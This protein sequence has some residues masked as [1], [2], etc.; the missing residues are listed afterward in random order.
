MLQIL[1]ISVTKINHKKRQALCLYVQYACRNDSWSSSAVSCAV[2]YLILLYTVTLCTS[3]ALTCSER[4][5]KILTSG[6]HQIM[7]IVF[8]IY[9]F[10]CISDVKSALVHFNKQKSFF[11]N[12]Q[13]NNRGLPPAITPVFLLT[14]TQHQLT[15]QGSPTRLVPAVT[16]FPLSAAN[17]FPV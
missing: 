15:R 16:Q 8:T 17:R 3:F 10:I 5:V 14:T 4:Q 7:H 11:Y 12:R 1:M 6:I 9:V 2:N 13:E